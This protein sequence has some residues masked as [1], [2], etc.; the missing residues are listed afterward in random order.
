MYFST[1]TSTTFIVMEFCGESLQLLPMTNIYNVLPKHR[2]LDQWQQNF[3]SHLSLARIEVGNACR[4]SKVPVSVWQS[5]HFTNTCGVLHNINE[6]NEEH[7]LP[8]WNKSPGARLESLNGVHK[9]MDIKPSV[10]QLNLLFFL[11]S[12]QVQITEYR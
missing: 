12:K 9:H 6:I 4:L 5:G 8:E 10:K 2:I 1:G 3:N 7:F 11:T